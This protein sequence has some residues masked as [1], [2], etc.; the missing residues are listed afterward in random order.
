MNFEENQIEEL[1]KVAPILRVSEEGGGTYILI[2]K[3]QLPDGCSPPIV[4][5]LLCP[6]LKDS[7]QST[8]F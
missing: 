5:A 1:R 6:F 2:E 7:Y 8:L 3:L 4:D